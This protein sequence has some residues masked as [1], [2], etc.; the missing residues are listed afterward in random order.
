ME[1]RPVSSLQLNVG[2]ERQDT[3][4]RQA[5]SLRRQRLWTLDG[6]MEYRWAGSVYAVNFVHDR[7][8]ISSLS[9]QTRTAP[10]LWWERRWSRGLISKISLFWWRE[11]L[12]EGALK[13]TFSSLSPRLSL[14]GR[15]ERLSILG[16]VELTDDLS[17]TVSESETWQTASTSRVTANALKLDLRPLPLALFR[18]QS[19]V[20]YTDREEGE[21]VLRHDLTLK[22]TLQF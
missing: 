1:V 17:W 7:L 9:T 19:Q 20:S 12:H 15:W 10:S 22:L 13:T 18:L 3:D 16:A 21:D 11:R 4:H 5:N 2:L 14:T 8:R 6:K